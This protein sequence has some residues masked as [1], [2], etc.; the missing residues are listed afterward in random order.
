MSRSGSFG[1]KVRGP[2]SLKPFHKSY[3]SGPFK[4]LF[5]RDIKVTLGSRIDGKGHFLNSGSVFAKQDYWQNLVDSTISPDHVTERKETHR[6]YF[7]RGN[8]DEDAE[9]PLTQPQKY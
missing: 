7:Q 2:S 9:K 4:I 3:R 6:E 8:R 5:T 1:S